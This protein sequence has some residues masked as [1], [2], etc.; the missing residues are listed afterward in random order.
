MLNID[1]I[2]ILWDLEL[3]ELMEFALH[4][5]VSIG[6]VF[7]LYY[8]FRI[9]SWH[10]K[11]K[12]YVIANTVIAGGLYLTTSFSERTPDVTDLIAFVYWVVGHVFYGLLLGVNLR[13]LDK[14]NPA[15]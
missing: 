7:V 11:V 2:P 12:P 10:R 13:Y 14:S 15:S 3:N 4:V 9:Y 6:I 5:I 1:Y 8:G